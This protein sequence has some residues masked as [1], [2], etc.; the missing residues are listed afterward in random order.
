[1]NNGVVAG[2]A[3][4]AEELNIFF[5]RFEVEAP[6]EAALQSPVHSSFILKVEEYEVRRMLRTINPR[7]AAGPDGIPGCVLK[8]CADQLAGVFTKIFNQSLAQSRVPSCL[9]SSTIVPVPKKSYISSLNDYRPVALTPV[10]MKCFEK[11]V[12]NYITSLLPQSFDPHQ[13]AYRANKSAEDAVAT[14]LHAALS[15]L[16]Q[17]GSYARLLFV[18]FSSAFNTILPHRL[19]VKLGDLGFPHSICMWI[20]SF[21]ARM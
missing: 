14:V 1:M 7:K 4:L 12:R 19:V 13:F 11:L 17:R 8:D 5:G 2:D 21:F 6:K 10:V 18:D 20:N 16:E 3:A 15:H 9:K